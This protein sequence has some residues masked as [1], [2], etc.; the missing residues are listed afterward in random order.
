MIP[1][2]VKQRS[3]GA[4]MFYMNSQA[5]SFIFETMLLNQPADKEGKTWA[6]KNY[7]LY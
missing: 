1:F 4:C 6:K 3:V 7:E 5:I 2:G